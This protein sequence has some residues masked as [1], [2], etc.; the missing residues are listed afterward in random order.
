M[1]PTLEKV[2]LFIEQHEM[3]RDTSGVV[4]AVS[5]GPD[6]VVLLDLLRQIPEERQAQRLH[7][8]HLN[9][10]L[11]GTESDDD[12]EFVRSLAGRLSIPVTIGSADVRGEAEAGKRGIEEVA[13]DA[14]YRFL[15]RVAAEH[16]CDRIAAGHTMSDQAETFLMRLARG[17]G[18]RGLSAMRPISPVPGF[19][20]ETERRGDR[21]TKEQHVNEQ[22]VG[23]AASPSLLL[24]IRPLLCLTREEVEEYCR[25][26]GLEFR[27][28]PSNLETHY[29]R[30]WVRLEVLPAL[31]KL[32]P[33]IVESIAR[34]TELAA[35]D[36]EALDLIAGNML[37]EACEGSAGEKNRREQ[38]AGRQGLQG[39]RSGFRVAALLDQPEGLRRRMIIEAINRH[40][41]KEAGD[42]GSSSTQI[43]STHIDA[44][45]AL[46]GSEASGKSITLPDG[47]RAWREFDKLVF[48]SVNPGEQ[49][50]PPYQFE[51]SAEH[52]LV[53]AGGFQ[54]T[55]EWQSDRALESALDQAKRLKQLVGSDWMMA[56]LNRSSLPARL[57]IRPRR[58]GERAHAV[59]QRKTKKLKKLMIDHRIPPS[60]RH[61]WPIVVTPD[62]RYVWSPGLP[63]AL[64]F[65]ASD[66]TIGLAI[67]RA[68]GA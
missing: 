57:I 22:K 15:R 58:R 53:E 4:V 42:R 5:G 49:A 13:R 35:A 2:R 60:L 21:E 38:G 41:M 46:L 52:P 67:L 36:Q 54:I 20:G 23:R 51:I 3:F 66:E 61:L 1:G 11:R 62:D 50:A 33:R 24:L 47:L 27:L 17:A 30:N 6:S 14:R 43:D 40:R 64:E 16:G 48:T 39:D 7:I 8:G 29:T 68:S 55:L 12:A 31:R 28:D 25:E 34:A 37:D 10:N 44:V 18:L 19:D 56:A 59:G 65:A 63:P 26:R 45:E 32:N 9:H